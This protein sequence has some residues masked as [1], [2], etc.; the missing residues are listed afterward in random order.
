A[1][2]QEAANRAGLGGESIT[3]KANAPSGA[4]P[5]K[6]RAAQARHFVQES[7]IANWEQT[8]PWDRPE[9]D[10]AARKVPGFQMPPGAARGFSARWEG[11]HINLNPATFDGSTPA[12]RRSLF[13]HEAGHGVAEDVTRTQKDVGPLLAPFRHGHQFVSPFGGVQGEHGHADNPA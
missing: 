10:F 12:S 1:R 11:D 6:D 13:Y 9:A 5:G 8:K 3:N 4:S 7:G 2:K